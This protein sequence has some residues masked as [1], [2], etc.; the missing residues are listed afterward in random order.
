MARIEYGEAS[1]VWTGKQVPIDE[2]A[3]GIELHHWH[4]I[5]ENGRIASEEDGVFDALRAIEAGEGWDVIGEPAQ[6]DIPPECAWEGPH[7]VARH[8]LYPV[9]RLASERAEVE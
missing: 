2:I 5:A 3:P 7:P 8:L 4:V 1:A 9:R 6:T